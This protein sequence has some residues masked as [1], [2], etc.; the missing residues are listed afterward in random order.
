MAGTLREAQS[1]GAYATNDNARTAASYGHGRKRFANDSV[2][3]RAPALFSH[4]RTKPHAT[5][6]GDVPFIAGDVDAFFCVQLI[7]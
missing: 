3:A 6:Y 7:N 1:A 4:G 5:S 2:A